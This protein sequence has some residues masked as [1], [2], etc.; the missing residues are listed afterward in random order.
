MSVLQGNPFKRHLSYRIDVLPAGLRTFRPVST[1]KAI[2]EKIEY[3]ASLLER[4][5]ETAGWAGKVVILTYKLDSFRG[6]FPSCI[7]VMDP[8][9]L[10]L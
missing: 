9:D 10:R 2:F 1:K 6:A 3:I 4:D 7:F 5:L 8:T